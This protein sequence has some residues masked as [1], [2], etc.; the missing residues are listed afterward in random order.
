METGD[1]MRLQINAQ[2]CVHCKTCDIKDPSQNINWVVPEG[3]GGP[4]Y[5]GMWNF[6]NV[7]HHVRLQFLPSNVPEKRVLILMVQDVNSSAYL[8]ESCGQDQNTT[9][10]N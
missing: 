1:G 4:A 5:N 8:S 10:F 3:G 2:N 6:L 7:I 9:C